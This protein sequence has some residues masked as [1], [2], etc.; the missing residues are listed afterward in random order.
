MSSKNIAAPT[1]STLALSRTIL[2]KNTTQTA[3][4][5]QMLDEDQTVSNSWITIAKTN[6]KQNTWKEFMNYEKEEK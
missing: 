2:L 5:M 1:N 6:I 4:A 3:I